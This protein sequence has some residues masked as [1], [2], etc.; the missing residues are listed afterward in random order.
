MNWLMQEKK[1]ISNHS[2]EKTFAIIEVMAQNRGV[3]RLQDIAASCGIPSSTALRLLNTLVRL[4]YV[5]QNKNDSQYRL[6]LKFSFISETILSQLDLHSL[7]HPHLIQLSHLCKESTCLAIDRDMTVVYVDVVTGPDNMIKT[8]QYIGKYAPMHCTGVGKLMLTNYDNEQ[9]DEYIRQKGLH[10]YT[11][12]TICT[13]EQLMTELSLINKNGYAIDDEECELGARCI[14]API[15]NYTNKVIACISVSGPTTRMNM[16]QL[17]YIK[18]II[19]D[20]A[21]QISVSMA[22][23]AARSQV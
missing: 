3:M 5:F 18:P 15:R 20:I 11:H 23:K 13:K 1:A 10:A 17:D 2:V 19:V 22:Y 7:I 16:K 21:M 4:G 12:H 8:M 14:A 6:S 9:L